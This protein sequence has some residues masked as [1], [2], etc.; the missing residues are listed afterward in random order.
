MGSKS[1]NEQTY[2]Q[3][4]ALKLAENQANRQRRAKKHHPDK[5]FGP[6]P[7]TKRGKRRFAKLNEKQKAHREAHWW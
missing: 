2:A 5:G 3:S 4:R 7:S 1:A 6:K